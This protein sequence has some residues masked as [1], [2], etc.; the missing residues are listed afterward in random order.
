VVIMTSNVGSH[1]ILESSGILGSDAGGTSDKWADVE[2]EVTKELRRHFKPEFLNRVDDIIVFHPLGIE[3]I[4]RIVDLQL[5]HLRKLLADRKIT[6]EITDD[7]KKLLA[8]EGYDPAFGGRP[9]KRTI[10]R[11]IQNPL[12]MAL[13][14]GQFKDGD[15][16][17]VE[18]DGKAGLTFST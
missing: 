9:L 3:Q 4:E 2:K 15:T 18:P 10:Q 1:Y 7:A 6:L 14:G 5:A 13:L 16:I 12:S 8:V 17:R 11:L